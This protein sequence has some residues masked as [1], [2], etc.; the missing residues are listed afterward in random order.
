M[1]TNEI[2]VAD[3]EK[4]IADMK[5]LKHDY[6]EAKK[7]AQEANKKLETQKKVVMEYLDALNKTS[8]KSDFG[9]VTKTTRWSWKVPKTEEDR[10]AFRNFLESRGEFDGMWSIHSGT[11]NAHCKELLEATQQTGDVGFSIPGLEPPTAS[12]TVSLTKR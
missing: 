4:S 9:V 1:T 6:D 7:V 5:Q 8:Y 2:T 10:G 11:M 3:F 12:F